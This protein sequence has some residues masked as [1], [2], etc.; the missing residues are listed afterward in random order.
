MKNR[1]V[2]IYG[3]IVSLIFAFAIG[4]FAFNLITEY[5]NGYERTQITFDTMAHNVKAAVEKNDYD[6]FSF[7]LENAVGSLYD[8]MSV[9][10]LL[11]GETYFSYPNAATSGGKMTRSLFKSDKVRDTN[12]Y[13]NANLYLL[14]PYTIFSFARISFLIILVTTVI[15]IILIIYFSFVEKRIVSSDDLQNSEQI[16]EDSQIEFY[17]ENQDSFIEN[18]ENAN[19][20]SETNVDK[21]NDKS[22][23]QDN[24]QNNTQIIDSDDEISDSNPDSELDI[25][26]Y[27]D[28]AIENNEDQIETE[29]K[30]LDE[31]PSEN[32]E[33]TTEADKTEIT[34][35]TEQEQTEKEDIK[36]PS[37]EVK[38]MEIKIEEA[39]P[40]GL[41]SPLTGFGWPQYFHTRLENELRR[42]TSSEIDLSLFIIRI[43]QMDKSDAVIGSICK[44]L[45]E[46]F[47]FADLIFEYKEDCFAAIKIA[48]NL[49]EA[50]NFADKLHLEI[51]RELL[52]LENHSYIGISTRSIRLISADRIL[53]EAEEALVHAQ[54]EPD[55]P[56]IA[57]RVDVAKYKEF[58]EKN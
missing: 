4:F 6:N 38:P 43:P 17:H 15:T 48:M 7:D 13:I 37:E 5:K 49:D 39:K 16:D 53:K 11:N 19:D 44:Y 34:E 31:K 41:F 29:E 27:E 58:V 40:E 51:E 55:S 24:L 54:A 30:N 50:L 21:D 28:A 9:E 46:Q 20:N 35:A 33:E 14:R 10:I 42:A 52:P 26:G 3:T 36:L 2:V 18:S 1:L 45:S 47:Q 12:I 57:F 22:S 23:I 25:P 8:Y 32:L 56:I